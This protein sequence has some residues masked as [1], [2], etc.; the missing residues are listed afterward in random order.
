MFTFVG[1]KQRFAR[2]FRAFEKIQFL[3]N[4]AKYEFKSRLVF[5]FKLLL[6]FP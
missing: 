4:K 6:F 2:Q 3:G 1:G 5:A